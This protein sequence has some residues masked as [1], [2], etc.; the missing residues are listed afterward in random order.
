MSL[1]ATTSAGRLT[2][3]EAR[4]QGF[5]VDTTTYPWTAYKGP[6]FAPTEW[7][8]CFT[9]HEAALRAALDALF[10]R[11]PDQPALTNAEYD[12]VRAAMATS[13]APLPPAPP[14]DDIPAYVDTLVAKR[15]PGTPIPRFPLPPTTDLLA[16]ALYVLAAHAHPRLNITFDLGEGLC[17]LRQAAGYTH[18]TAP[19]EPSS[20]PHDCACAR[21]HRRRLHATV[22]AASTPPA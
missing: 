16:C 8:D 10:Y 11:Q 4:D 6:R 19:A 21:A 9:E 13:G 5:T 2:P 1:N 17:R 12:L 14:T 18:S 20:E 22:P 15:A 7:R 3:G